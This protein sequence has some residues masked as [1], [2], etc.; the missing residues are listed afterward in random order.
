MF[1]GKLKE[2]PKQR[3][4]PV[5]RERHGHTGLEVEAV[6]RMM[7]G[8][9]RIKAGKRLEREARARLSGAMNTC[10]AG[11]SATVN[12]EGSRNYFERGQSF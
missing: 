7:R 11:L 8:S 6:Q 9:G 3:N 5:E 10:R 4:R 12:G 1:K 2:Q